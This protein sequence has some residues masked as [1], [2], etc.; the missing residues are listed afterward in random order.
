MADDNALWARGSAGE[1]LWPWQRVRLES[2]AT[3]ERLSR[4]ARAAAELPEPVYRLRAAQLLSGLW[5]TA[6]SHDPEVHRALLP[7]L[8]PRF[9]GPA[10]AMR[11]EYV[12]KAALLAQDL[13]RYRWRDVAPELRAL[14]AGP[15]LA[16]VSLP[17]MASRV[18][19]G[20]KL[21]ALDTLP[22]TDADE[23]LLLALAGKADEPWPVRA[24]ALDRLR[25][26][27]EAEPVLLALMRDTGQPASVRA[28]AAYRLLALNGQ[29]HVD[30][31]AALL[32]EAPVDDRSLPLKAAHETL[33]G[34]LAGRL[35]SGLAST[36]FLVRDRAHR[37]LVDIGCAA[38]PALAELVRNAT[39]W[40]T[41]EQAEATLR[42]I[43]F[44][45]LHTARTLREADGRSLSPAAPGEA[46]ARR[47]LSRPDG[48]EPGG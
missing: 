29:P 20:A 6:A 39:V 10:E 37:L 24:K 17:V 31:I 32:L 26:A 18:M 28:D 45:A 38:V 40:Q 42:E 4:L 47:G 12:A 23:A 46:D 41:R 11:M 44:D 5:L 2:S 3:P 15:P 22:P 21:F 25:H 36:S 9:D 33:A 1:W 13:L 30:E 48:G 8:T 34:E 35:V 19:V 43:D 7:A 14:L 27:P 16:V